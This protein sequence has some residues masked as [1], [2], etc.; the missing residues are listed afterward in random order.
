[1][2]AYRAD[3]EIGVRGARS[4]EQLRSSINQTAQAVSS[5]NDVVSARG[6]L[7]QNIQNYVNNLNTAARSLELVGAGTVAETRAVREYVRA[8]GEANTARAR[9][10]SLVAQEIANQRRVTPGNAGVGQQGP[11]LPPALIQAQKVRQ[12]WSQ[13]FRD[14]EG[15]ATDLQ[16]SAKA[17]AL[18]TR[19][20]WTKFFDDAS[21]VAQDLQATTQRQA[22]DTKASWAKFFMQAEDVA[23]ELAQ[24]VQRIRT[25]EGAASEA[26]RQRLAEQAAT[27]QRIRDAGFGVQGPALP[28]EAA[29]RAVATVID[30]KAAAQKRLNNLIAS[31]QI[32][33]QKFL[34]QKVRGLNVSQQLAQVEKLITDAQQNKTNITKNYLTALDGVLNS[35]RNE[36]KLSKAIADTQK[37]QSRPLPQS[38]STAKSPVSTTSKRGREALSNA[39]IGG[40]F[41]L[42]FGQGLGASIGGG[43]GGGLGGLL[44][45]QF[46]FAL[47]LVGTALGQTFDNAAQSA[48]D[49]SKALKDTGDAS[50]AL[51]AALG[52]VDKNTKTVIENLARSG[53]Q[54]AAA[55]KAFEVLAAEIGTEQAEAFKRAG[56]ATTEWG[57][58]VQK[59]LTK[60]YANVVLLG[61]ALKNIFP[62]G[63]FT[64][65]PSSVFDI[66]EAQPQQPLNQEARDRIEDLTG[67][68][69]LL[70]KQVDLARLTVDASVDQRLQLERQI[71]LQEYVNDA[72]ELERQLKQKL[73]SEQEF[74][75]KLKAAELRLTQ[76]L[77]EVENAAQQARQR[78]AEETQRAAEKAQREAERAAD[79]QL[80]TLNNI[81]SLQVSLVEQALVSADV[82]VDR[83]KVSEG[84]ISA[85][86]ESINQ[87]QARLNLEARILD[88]QLEQ[89]LATKDITQQERTL[90]EAIYKQQKANLE[91][92]YQ[93]K[94]RIQQL[95]LA[96]LQTARQIL[97]AEK[98]RAVEDIRQQRGTQLAGL[99][100]QLAFPEGGE[101]FDIV[102]QRLEQT[103]RRY[104]ILVPLQ[105]EL[106]NLETERLNTATLLSTQQQQ[107]LDERISGTITKIELEQQYLNQLDATEKAVLKQQAVYEQYAPIAQGI[108]NAFGQAFKE[109]STGT[110]TAQEVLTNFFQSV[111][112]QFLDMAAQI[113]SKWIQMMILNSILKLFPGG[114]AAAGAGANVSQK[115]VWD[116]QMLDFR[117]N[118]GPVSAGSP[119]IVGER[120]P[121]LFVPGRSGTIVPN[122]KM[123][124]DNVSVVVNVDAKGTNVQG[125]DQQGNQ[126]G[127]AISAAVQQE[128]IKQK[129][130]GGLLA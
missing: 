19:T 61:E 93:T 119:Y 49:F 47:S 53:Q 1:V 99:Q 48:S 96:R 129:R 88:I 54:A 66:V 59:W 9:Q 14:A 89:Q 32:L 43:V 125:N 127:R 10:N 50:A 29:A 42:L 102:N 94:I 112:D 35:L 69:A 55:E 92:Q 4:L 84:E 57:S 11:A 51:E 70:Q 28:P 77:F 8:L 31:A 80:Q 26:A 86:K 82:D 64:G 126:L 63:S 76:Q 65:Q 24:Q 103:S 87:Q 27:R 40:A 108:G 128:L 68:N 7:V 109:I 106:Q 36:L 124:S 60:T 101:D 114:N 105:R 120:G 39:V 12:K 110:L 83:V 21:G 71:A 38:A 121:E 45:G 58:N 122:D 67:Q 85:L 30:T 37:A 52:S 81:R 17:K 25:R 98:G 46:G 104:E 91:A 5:L 33:E 111:A 23:N 44:G 113:I 13:F 3:I 62:N 18:N 73:L 123:G 20:K 116:P 95:D 2:A 117:A 79:K 107:D 6:S 74:S 97:F 75:L 115:L 90:Y 22:Q 78:K 56:E 130:P 100:A 16:V 41:P 34:Q 118:G 15:V 72:T